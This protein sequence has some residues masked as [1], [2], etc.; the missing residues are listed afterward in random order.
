[1]AVINRVRRFWMQVVCV[2]LSFFLSGCFISQAP[3]ISSD[4]AI[5]PFQS[6]TLYD[7]SDDEK[8][9]HTLTRNGEVYFDLAEKGKGAYLFAGVGE[10]L[11]IVQM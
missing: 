5:Y 7:V 9:A 10:D 11:F 8:E 1:M 4:N 6:I 3:L 2:S